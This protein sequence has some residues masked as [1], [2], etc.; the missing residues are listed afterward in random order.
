[1]SIGPGVTPDPSPPAPEPSRYR[2]VTMA[3]VALLVIAVTL[4]AY[5]GFQVTR[6]KPSPLRVGPRSAQGTGGGGR[7]QGG[8][9]LRGMPQPERKIV[10]AYDTNG[11]HRLDSRERAVARE[12]LGTQRPGGFGGRGRFGGGGMNSVP[13]EPGMHLAP[14]D[15]R[16]YPTAPVY[17]QSAL[18]TIFLKFENA[19]WE[20]EL[21]AFYGTD[22]DVPATAT[23]DGKIYKEVGVHFRGNSSYRMV[24]EGLKHSLNVSF[25]FANPDQHLGGYRTLNLLNA[26]GDPTF[27][28]TLLYSEIARHYLA[29]PLTN[30][31]RVVIN[32]ESWG[33]YVNEQ[34]FNKDFLRDWFKTETGARWKVPGSPR[35]RGGLEYLGD[36]ASQ[37]K[38]IYE[39]KTKDDPAA[40]AALVNL[41]R[42]L[43]QT[44]P[45]KL[46]A[47]LA[48]VLDI[49]A[50][51]KFLALDNA[52]VNSDGYWTRAS[53]YAIYLD[54]RGKF[55]ILP[56][57]FNEAF[58]ATES[59]RRGF[60]P[61]GLAAGA[62]L[63]PLVGLEDSAKPLRSK[64][65]AVPALRQ[66]Y[67]ADVR[68]IATEWLDWNKVGLLVARWQALIE[69]D[70]RVDGR[71]L[72]STAAF[73]AN[74]GARAED[75]GP[76]PEGTL[77]G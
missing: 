74:V 20:Q 35:G 55:H 75:G 76:A 21:A 70:V 60:G 53:D 12:A 40:W 59:G 45:A 29:V 17:D 51:L 62:D 1:M 34:Q 57:D 4:V 26:N 33:V 47:A 61:P 16:S 23:L 2:W 28:R 42:L 71:K 32:G 30:Y 69:S 54:D 9:G 6:P 18:R 37:Y 38:G 41:C 15:V 73:T 48:P 63:D 25:D 7:G 13:G 44:P 43:N 77:R 36:D 65:L 8:W 5:V 22:V 24:P 49:D 56:L 50:T 3:Q 68:Q 31:M 72:Y 39:I 58:D 14:A 46:E 11:D 19:D 67:L 64:L 10:K 52:L 66:R 27:V